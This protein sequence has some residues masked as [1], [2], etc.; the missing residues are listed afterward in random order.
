MK[1]LSLRW[2]SM[3]KFLIKC[4]CLVLVTVTTFS[5]CGC[6]SFKPKKF[7]IGDFKFSIRYGDDKNDPTTYFL[8]IG[9]SEAGQKKKTI[10]L[11]KRINGHPYRLKFRENI[12]PGYYETIF[13]GKVEKFYLEYP[14]NYSED[15]KEATLQFSYYTEEVLKKV[16]LNIE[17]ET[18]IF[19]TRGINHYYNYNIYKKRMERGGQLENIVGRKSRLANLQFLYNYNES[20]NEGH[21]WIDDIDNGEKIEVMPDTPEREGYTFGGWYNEKECINK[22]DFNT[23]FEKPV[24][25]KGDIY[26]EDYVTYVY[27]KWTQNKK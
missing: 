15:D 16:I 22:F 11:P 17:I 20:P 8:M 9:L 4:I 21:F 25:N 13:T 14:G 24:L 7:D 26:P 5:L 23:V 2:K 1:K 12:M 27:A 10:V 18:S 6:F 3:K 19:A